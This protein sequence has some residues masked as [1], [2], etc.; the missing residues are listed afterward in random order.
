MPEWIGK[1]IGKVRIEKFLARGGMAEVYL[2][3]H[4]TLARPV[5]VKVLHS[6]KEQEPI[7]LERFQREAKAVAAMRHPNIVQIHDFDTIDGH[8]YIVMEYL[9]GPTLVTYLQR[10]RKQRIP[11]PQV[12][13]LL[14][15]LAAALD[16][17]HERGIIHRDI[18]PANILLH[19]KTDEIP[20]DQ[21]LPEDVEA[22][23]TDFGLVRLVDTD[24][25]TTS[26]M[27]SGTPAYMSPEQARGDKLDHRSDIYSLGIVLYELLAGRVPFKA[28]SMR[29]V[30][31]MQIHATPLPI[32]ELPARVQAVLD[33]ALQKNPKDRYQS[34]LEL[35]LDFSRSIGLI[36]EPVKSQEPEPVPPVPAPPPIQTPARSKRTS[37]KPKLVAPPADLLASKN[38]RDV[39]KTLKQPALWQDA[40][41]NFLTGNWYFISIWLSIEVFLVTIF[42][43]YKSLYLIPT[44]RWLLVAVLFTVAA[45]SAYSW[46]RHKVSGWNISIAFAA[47]LAFAGLTGW[48]AWQIIFPE[49]FNPQVFGIVVAEL[50]EGGSLQS[51]EK[52]MEISNQ[53]YEHVCSAI[54]EEF[55]L[56][57]NIDP[58][59][60]LSSDV[61]VK[62]I[63]VIPDSQT[64]L[65]YGTRV[66]A[67]VV[68]WG[69]VLGSSGKDVTIRFR[70]LETFD[71]AVNPEFPIVLPVKTQYT[72]IFIKE[73]DLESDP[74]KIKNIIAE[75]ST[76]ISYFTLGLIAYL[77]RNFPQAVIDFE[78]ATQAAE[79]PELIISPEGKSLLYFYLGRS[80]HAIGRFAEGQRWLTRAQEVN[81]GE[82]A[83]PI[84]LAIGYG[85]Q[86]L[87]EE[88]E[89]QLDLALD[90]I[91]TWLETSPGDNVATYD[92]GLVFQIR[93]QYESAIFDY[94]AIIDRD[95]DYYV[96][97]VTLGQVASELRDY[98][99]AKDT[100]QDAIAL[101]EKSGANPAWAYLNLGLVYEK[102][103]DVLPAK[104][105]FQQAIT[106]A[107]TTDAMYLQYARFLEKQQEMDGALL[108]YKKLLEVTKDQGWGYSILAGF[109]RRLG[110]LE[111]ALDSYKQA[112]H[113]KQTDS[114]L[115]SY[116]AETYFEL[117]H[118]ED[119][120]R[121]F[122]VAIR[123]ADIYY[124]YASYGSVLFQLGKFK[125]AAEM[126]QEALKRR[127]IDYAVLLNL[128]HTYEA[129]GETAKAIQVY[130]Q[131]IRMGDQLP[132]HAIQDAQNRLQALED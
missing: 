112:V 9:K 6:Y 79:N 97:Y 84:G 15:G 93:K 61:Q 14:N 1:T 99:R 124:S 18:K 30:I 22:V 114:L 60:D 10:Q 47:S 126:Y 3:M 44:G 8:P 109:Y 64:A 23:L 90:L 127:P 13:R 98:P 106:H 5:A 123:S 63:G 31:D 35:A 85:G 75:Q 2:A 120:E 32:P 76:I 96:A 108:N 101:S 95:P 67:D 19:N 91:N 55:Q 83:I 74:K 117:G 111:Q 104:A 92:R 70:V 38:A 28:D 7:S 42:W 53:V 56:G 118:P 58:C 132:D 48:Q 24:T 68:I 113:Y 36:A 65:Q 62:R 41:W 69:Q 43:V 78:K 50:G 40:V 45:W 49:Q 71:R 119:A 26:D 59:K 17:A 34:S 89:T 39:T 94:Q 86:G 100:F 29:M 21:P 54:Q 121:E 110:L 37:S 129:L 52:T 105:A 81:P 103:G 27:I 88:K 130:Q 80:N 116:L 11:H 46:F 73:L 12:A 57:E 25:H 115:R 87:D 51:T 125:R 77:D 66:Q 102:T 72:E 128:G 82:P 122:E 33:R 16:Y 131:M 20:L 107:P 4:V